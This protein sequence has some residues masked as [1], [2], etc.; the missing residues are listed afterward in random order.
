[1]ENFPS[2][3]KNDTKEDSFISVDEDFLPEDSIDENNNNTADN[4]NLFSKNNY[5]YDKINW[6]L[7]ENEEEDYNKEMM[8]GPENN[9][10]FE[11]KDPLFYFQLFLDENFYYYVSTES[12]KYFYKKCE[13]EKNLNNYKDKLY[14]LDPLFIRKYIITILSM[15]LVD[16]PS[17]KLFWKKHPLFENFFVK[18]LISKKEFEFIVRF[19]HFESINIV[20]D[21]ISKIRYLVN[22]FNSLWTKYSPFA[23]TYTIDE[24][25]VPYR[26][27]L[28][29]KQYIPNKPI[30]Y[31]IK[32]YAIADSD[33]AYVR[34]WHIYSG[35]YDRKDTDNI[36]LELLEG[37]ASYSHI[38]M[39][40][41]FTNFPLLEHLHKMDYYFTCSISKNKKG[42]PNKEENINLE[43]NKIKAYRSGDFLLVKFKNKKLFFAV[44]NYYAHRT[45]QITEKCRS[46]EK[47]QE[48]SEK[49]KY[50]NENQIEDKNRKQIRKPECI[51]N[52]NLLARGVDKN[53]QL[54]SFYFSNTRSVKWYKKIFLYAVEVC[55][56]NSYILFKKYN[57]S[58]ISV[59][60]FKLR[61]IEAMRDSIIEKKEIVSDKIYADRLK[62]KH[63]LEKNS[64]NA[65]RQCKICSIKKII[66]RS[67]YHCHAC[68]ISLCVEGC[69]KIYHTKKELKLI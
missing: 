36:V 23:K 14:L 50:R 21:K 52:Y 22:Y 3:F 8:I 2:K 6:N 26:G 47:Q 33:T 27:K 28:G 61:I 13:T 48:E 67:R 43:S 35:K 54:A 53:N 37:V 12:R 17:Y 16:L 60:D 42:L 59:F 64:E 69:F 41:H 62:G 55:L 40:S 10:G 4:L 65:Q 30:K 5:N 31:G 32:I 15:G 63:F 49:I 58:K 66:R 7:I 9:I 11:D 45:F 24:T 46:E 25:M 57:N 38:F 44:T 39:D 20:H 56:I 34:K 29:I 51:I 1:M 18:S 68:K 19:L